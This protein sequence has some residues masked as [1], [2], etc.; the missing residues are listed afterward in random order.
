MVR[1]KGFQLS[2]VTVKGHL[3]DALA[4]AALLFDFLTAPAQAFQLCACS[5]IPRREAASQGARL[6][7]A[8]AKSVAAFFAI[9]AGTSIA[10]PHVS[11]LAALLKDAHPHWDP[12]TIKSAIMTTAYT[13][14]VRDRR[15][16]RSLHCQCRTV[17]RPEQCFIPPNKVACM[18]GLAGQSWP[19]LASPWAQFRAQVPV[20][21]AAACTSAHTWVIE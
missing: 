13:V 15:T 19:T 12:M 18:Y 2:Y 10:C 8:Y 20:L 7:V 6:H 4:Y 3:Q 1:S 17:R 9:A 5:N 16:L 14:R 11:G 21:A